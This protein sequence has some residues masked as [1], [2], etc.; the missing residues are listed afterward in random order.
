MDPRAAGAR[1]ARHG[2]LARVLHALNA[3]IVLLLLFSGLALGDRLP[4]AWVDALGGHEAFSDLHEWLGL[5]F[6]VASALLIGALSRH[7]AALVRRLA[8]WRR[9]DLG[10]PLAFARHLLRSQRTDAP[11]HS[12]YFDPLERLV[13]IIVLATLVLAGL[14]GVYLYWSPDAPRWAFVVF[15]RSHIY[16]GWV[17]LGALGLHIFAG[18]GVLPTHR[19]ILGV[20]FGDGSLPQATARRLWPGWTERKLGETRAEPVD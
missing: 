20:M 11:R 8:E 12:G 4:E 13:L 18:L 14:S 16:A 9:G 1:I 3:T 2:A 10:W 15:I 7:S 17:L 19:G 5:A 6:V